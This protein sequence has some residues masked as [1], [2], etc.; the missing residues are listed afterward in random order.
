MADT[1]L[2]VCIPEYHTHPVKPRGFAEFVD[3]FSDT[4]F[5]RPNHETVRGF[6]E[7]ASLDKNGKVLSRTWTEN[8]VTD[9]GASAMLENAYNNTEAAGGNIPIFNRLGLSNQGFCA[10]LSAPT[11][12][13]ATTSLSVVALAAPIAS[14]VTM[15]L[16]SGG[17]SPQTVT[18][19]GAAALNAT[20]LAVNS[21]TPAYGGV[22]STAYPAGTPLV[23][24]GGGGA[25]AATDDVYTLTIQPNRSTLAYYDSGALSAGAFTFTT[26][27]GA[28][29]RKVAIVFTFGVQTGTLMQSNYCELW[30]TNAAQASITATGKSGNH[31]IFP[32]QTI[33]GTTQ[34][35]V[36]LNITL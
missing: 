14:G 10:Q 12:T 24:N 34:L 35:Q 19:S 6:W 26:T 36:T 18:L 31:L 16:N 3:M 23:A 8:I 29:A 28:G 25:P 2:R 33:N 17:T 20:S 4:Q 21:F 11:G 15:S 32:Y 30:T 7:L 13:G 5:A 27:G 9:N 22:A 1:P